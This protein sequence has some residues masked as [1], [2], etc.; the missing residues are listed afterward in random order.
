MLPAA[1]MSHLDVALYEGQE[2]NSP[3]A[4]QVRMEA[5]NLPRNTLQSPTPA[6]GSKRRRSSSS[7]ESV[8][9]RP[10]LLSEAALKPVP[11]EP[12]LPELCWGWFSPPKAPSD[13]ASLGDEVD[14]DILRSPSASLTP[15]QDSN[16][17]KSDTTQN[18]SSTS[19]RKKRE[20]YL[21]AGMVYV[22]PKDENFQAAIL[23]PLGVFVSSSRSGETKPI[24]IF[25]LQSSTPKSRVILNKQDN[26][27]AEITLDF[28]QYQRRQYDKHALSMLC[29][30]SIV[31]RDRWI[32]A[33]LVGEDHNIT[34]SVRRDKWK[35]K[36]EGPSIPVGGYTY[37]W[38][39][40][41][42]TTYGVSIR[43]F[44]VEDRRALR[45]EDCQP[46]LA[47]GEA[48]CP[49]L[50]VEYKCRANNGKASEAKDQNTAAS[51]LWLHQR[52]EIRQALGLGLDDLKHF[53]ITIVDSIYTVSEAQFRD[54]FYY[55]R[56]LVRGLL[57]TMDGLKLYIEWNNAIHS[58]GLGANA[59]S[60]KEDIVILLDRLRAQPN[61]PWPLKKH[62]PADAP[63]QSG[64]V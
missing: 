10:S 53:S 58:W 42:D 33:P 61:F 24:E 63:Q 44:D 54:G 50:T 29:S 30:D 8:R 45:L 31:P 32:D 38:D 1:R 27:L 48:V 41:P 18:T 37:D 9:K 39:I 49:Y 3:T 64:V 52:K 2:M 21:E 5:F 15:S 51:V 57:T 46:W 43:M 7:P 56:D 13:I 17:T 19:S 20:R 28:Q 25:G 23:D 4:S 62:S 11:L 16:S 22:G 35:P 60:F 36:K 47:E 12:L 6:P 59:S 34:T 26:E 14:I 55:L 40:E